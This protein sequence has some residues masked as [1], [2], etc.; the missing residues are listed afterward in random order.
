MR[1]E[2]VMSDYWDEK[3]REYDVREVM[4]NYDGFVNNKFRAAIEEPKR[5]PVV[6]DAAPPKMW[7]PP[8]PPTLYM[9]RGLPASGKST[10]ALEMLKQPR[11]KRINK[12]LLREMLDGGQYSAENEEKIRET[13]DALILYFLAAY[14]D[15]VVDDTNLDPKHEKHLRGVAAHAS[16]RFVVVN[17]D[18]PLDEC[19]RRDA[20]RT[21]PVG[22]AVIRGMHKKWLAPNA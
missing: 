14:Y 15:V 9:M 2:D 6:I 1:S 12:D 18:T 13:R 16:A 19:I 22:E 5:E 7:T 20:A 11:T 8:E 3:N 10:I 21:K 4:S 17:V